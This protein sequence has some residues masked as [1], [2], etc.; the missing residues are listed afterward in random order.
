MKH[1]KF[2]NKVWIQLTF[3]ALQMSHRQPLSRNEPQ[4]LCRS[5][6]NLVTTDCTI[7]APVLALV[8]IRYRALYYN[9]NY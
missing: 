3:I 7:A 8:K 6:R 2:I 5:A 4:L 1:L 9:T